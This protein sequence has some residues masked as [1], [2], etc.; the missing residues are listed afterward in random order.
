[1]KLAD[2]SETSNR[3]DQSDPPQGPAPECP[4]CGQPMALRTARKGPR[5][6]SRFWGCSAFPACKGTRPV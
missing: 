5:V 3:S 1:M 4:L 6:G 2:K